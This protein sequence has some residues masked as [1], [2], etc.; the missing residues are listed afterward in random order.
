MSNPLDVTTL[1]ASRDPSKDQDWVQA[2]N[3]LWKKRPLLACL[4]VDREE[5]VARC[6]L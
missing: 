6:A 4:R 3:G 2:A 5:L 1:K